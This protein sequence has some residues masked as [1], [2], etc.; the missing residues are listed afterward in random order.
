MS[1]QPLTHMGEKLRS[2]PVFRGRR[3]SLVLAS[4]VNPEYADWEA[5]KKENQQHGRKK[6]KEKVQ[7][8]NNLILGET[9]KQDKGSFLN[10]PAYRRDWVLDIAFCFCKAGKVHCGRIGYRI[11]QLLDN[12][13]HKLPEIE[14]ANSLMI[15][16]I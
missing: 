11:C 9:S 12:S 7:A 16:R 14:K 6:R 4:R 3:R 13:Y 2:N 1:F 5:E 8:A 10:P 15:C